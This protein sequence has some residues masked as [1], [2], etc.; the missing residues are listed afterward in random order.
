MTSTWFLAAGEWPSVGRTLV[1]MGLLLFAASARAATIRRI[2]IH[3]TP[4]F[5]ADENAAGLGERATAAVWR[6]GNRSVVMTKE[7]VIR[8]ELLIADG[9]VLDEGKL[10]ETV[11]LLKAIPQIADA[12]AAVIPVGAEEAAPTDLVDVVFTVR[13]N[14]PY[15]MDPELRYEGDQPD[16]TLPLLY[17]NVFGTHHSARIDL[18]RKLERTIVRNVYAGP[19]VFGGHW[20]VR[21][22]VE[23]AWLNPE[24]LGGRVARTRF[25]GFAAGVT[26]GKPF[27][28]VYDRWR[29]SVVGDALEGSDV[30]Y[31]GSEP[32]RAVFSADG[33]LLDDADPPTGGVALPLWGYRYWRRTAG[34]AAERS[35]GVRLKT[36]M[37]FFADWYRTRS[38]HLPEVREEIV[39]GSPVDLAYR[40]RIFPIEDEPIAGVL[41][42]QSRP[43]FVAMHDVD[44]FKST[45]YELVGWIAGVAVGRADATFGVDRPYT[46]IRGALT[47]GVNAGPHVRFAGRSLAFTRRLDEGAWVQTLVTQQARVYLLAGG[48][49]SMLL[50]GEGRAGYDATGT[51]V[52]RNKYEAGEDTVRASPGAYL[53]SASPG[54]GGVDVHARPGFPFYGG[55]A[56]GFR[57]FRNNAFVGDRYVLTTAEIRT[58]SV[59]LASID[60]GLALFYDA[61]RVYFEG[62][63]APELAQ[64]VGLG[65]RIQIVGAFTSLLRLD[66]AYAISGVS[67]GESRVPVN[68]TLE[69]PF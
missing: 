15:E 33:V 18:S 46:E 4:P 49:G 57:A 32:R 59:N 21:E 35:F 28:S 50:E 19:R 41:V 24:N 62:D 1:L 52:G 31:R 30:L 55:A 54:I 11:R 69:Q 37:G 9:E 27:R 39:P 60:W 53:D 25:D 68:F 36:G 17:D 45:E 14:F 6:L 8:R 63:A 56:T 5:E 10:A 48:M 29:L 44:G 3:R 47:W 34:I 58:G 40:A 7:W 12:S 13:M 43:V 67:R 61:G 16:L 64:D 22:R 38:E 26:V 23:G 66:A 20:N 65:L 2:E 51:L 42:S